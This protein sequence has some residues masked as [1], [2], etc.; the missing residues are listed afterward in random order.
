MNTQI[1]GWMSLIIFIL[2]IVVGIK[3]KV[4]L[5]ILAIAVG[6]LLGF[7][8]MTE[9]G[10]MSAVELKGKPIIEL[11]PFEIFWMIVSVSLM[12]NVGSVNGAFDIVIKKLV[13]LTGGRRALIP[14]YV[15]VIIAVACVAGLGTS[16]VVILLCTIASNIAKDQD[17]DPIFM[18][19]TVLIGT[20]VAIGSPVGIIGI[21]C[22]GYTQDLWGQSIAP[23]YMLPHALALAVLTFAFIYVVFRGWKLEKWPQQKKEEIPKL[24]RD[25]ILSLIGMAVFV[26]LSIV[27]GFNLGL[28]AFLVAA[29]LL[30][31]GCA[32]E[33][34]VIA[35]V[36]W[37]SVLMISGMCMLIGIVQQ[38]GGMDLLT[39]ALE[40]LMNRYTV[41]PLY[42]LIGSLLSLVSSLTGVTLPSMIPT[43]PDIAEAT[44]VNPFSIV[45]SL[46]FGANCTVISPL[47]SMGAIAIG[48]MGSNP[49]W[50]TSVLFKRLM[51]WAFIIMGIAALLAGIGVA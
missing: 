48:I 49:N 41:K 33:K 12:L 35:T 50:D 23:S 22:N 39:G 9:G 34:K 24:N 26:V 30:L 42:S 16:G 13:G 46:T 19:M 38:A 2:T 4:N 29:A 7:F 27:M 18:M 32:D 8:V 31:L 3:R 5:G 17:I 28:S 36:P 51:I 14:V 40:T 11:F 10:S 44:G 15:F 25:Q 6:F 47:N 20:T 1:I 45:T 37:S 43:I 21:I